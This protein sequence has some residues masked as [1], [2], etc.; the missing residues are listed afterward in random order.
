LFTAEAGWT[1][2]RVSCNG[3]YT[4]PV[5]LLAR[6]GMRAHQDLDVLISVRNKL[7]EAFGNDVVDVDLAC[8][9]GFEIH[10]P[11]LKNRQ[12]ERSQ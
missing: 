7:V 9:H 6:S 8:D 11:V 2:L 5:C 3:R 12:C 10:E 1:Y 4:G